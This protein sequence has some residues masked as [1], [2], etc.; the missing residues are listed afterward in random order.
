MSFI[1]NCVKLSGM[2]DIQGAL[3]IQGLNGQLGAAGEPYKSGRT[4]LKY[5]VG[6]IHTDSTH[7]T[8]RI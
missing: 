8:E 1:R 5:T 6:G 7:F 4:K 2:D 3:M